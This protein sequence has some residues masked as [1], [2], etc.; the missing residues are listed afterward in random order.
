MPQGHL[1]QGRQ[2]FSINFDSGN[3]KTVNESAVCCSVFA[4]CSINSLNPKFAE[5]PFRALRSRN[6]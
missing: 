4:T 5:F 1:P 6:A 2:D 3:F